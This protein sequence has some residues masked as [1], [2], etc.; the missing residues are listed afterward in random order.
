MIKPQTPELLEAARAYYQAR[1]EKTPDDP[2]LL[3][4]L[5]AVAFE[6]AKEAE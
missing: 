5:G 2:A 3:A 6:M 1:L 4:N